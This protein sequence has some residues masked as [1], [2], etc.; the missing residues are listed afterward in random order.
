ML[1]IRKLF[2]FY[3]DSQVLHGL[4]LAIEDR[5]RIAIMGRNGAGKSTLLKSVMNAGP[6][7]QGEVIFAGEALGDMTSFRRARLGISFVPEDRR[8]FPH[9]TVLE[10]LLLMQR[11]ATGDALG[12]DDLLTA[13]PMLQPLVARKGN[14]LSGGQQ[15]ML[16][17]ARGFLPK[18]RLLLIDEPTEGLAPIIVQ[19]LA[20]A[21][22]TLCDRVGSTLILSEQNLAFARRCT[23]RVC[24]LD[25][26]QIVFQGDWQQ[27]DANPEVKTRYLA[28]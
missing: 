23:S 7:T 28:V 15:Q 13:F 18:P 25:S 2:A 17:V 3:G 19:Q 26:G 16:A 8:I 14:Q 24:V 9:M 12:T 4:D 11:V 6:T 20:V 1:D 22:S 27:F 10:N 5:A 21:I